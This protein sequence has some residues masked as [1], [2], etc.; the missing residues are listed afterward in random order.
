MPI[1][2][3]TLSLFLLPPKAGVRKINGTDRII[4]EGQGQM[5]LPRAIWVSC[6][7]LTSIVVS[8]DL[9]HSTPYPCPGFVTC[10]G[11]I[12]YTRIKAC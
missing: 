3:Y 7:G 8:F 12:L 10:L 6:T 11:F 9:L 5:S 4:N 2:R 1:F